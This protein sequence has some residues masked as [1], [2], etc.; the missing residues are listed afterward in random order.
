MGRAYCPTNLYDFTPKTAEG[1]LQPQTQ[2]N[3]LRKDKESEQILVVPRSSISDHLCQKGVTKV[4]PTTL[5]NIVE[6]NS[7]F[8]PR[9]QAEVDPNFKQIIPY[10]IFNFADQLFL[11]RRSKE[12]SEKR[13]ADKFSLGIGG[14]LRQE[15]LTGD[16]IFLW[17]QREFTEEVEFKSSVNPKLIGLINDDTNSVGQVHTGIVW[18]VQA[19]SPEISVKEELA[20]G[21]LVTLSECQSVYEQLESWSQIVVDHLEKYGLN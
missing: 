18:M 2:H 7:V 15:D 20:S 9:G 17:A 19:N 5:K 12:A 10:L 3:V 21:N 8:I 1:R 11:M 16:D 13:L 4:D 14:H 6:N